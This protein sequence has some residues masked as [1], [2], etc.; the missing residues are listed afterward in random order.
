[1]P[2]ETRRFFLSSSLLLPP[3]VLGAAQHAHQVAAGAAPARLEFLDAASAADLEALAEEILPATEEGP[4]AKQAGVIYFIDRALASFDKAHRDLYRKGLADARQRAA[5]SW[6]SVPSLAALTSQQRIQ[7]LTS[8]EDS[9]FFR[10]L[11]RHTHI[12]F[13]ADPSWGGNRG[14]AGWTLIGF[15]GH[16]PYKPPF[17]WYDNPENGA[18]Q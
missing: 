13:F 7:L 14:R 4:G 2:L 1:M 10:Q 12:G 8:I 15:E 3:A 9:P 6:S 5:A 17:G 11:A 16:A 18:A